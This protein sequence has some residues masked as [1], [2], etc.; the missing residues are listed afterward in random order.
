MRINTP[1]TIAIFGG[2]GDLT[3]KKLAPAL[4]DLFA[5]GHLP[6]VFEI[7]GFSRRELTTADYR[8][9]IREAIQEKG[10]PHDM[11][12]LERFLAHVRYVVGDFTDISDYEK[13]YTE[14]RSIDEEH[15]QCMSKL[16]YLAVPPQFYDEIFDKLAASKLTS[17]CSSDGSWTRVVVE[18]PFGSD[19]E[20]ARRLDAKLE[21]LFKEEQIY[22]IDHYL[23]KETIEN[24]LAFRFSNALFE[25]IWNKEHIERIHV[26]MHEEFGV[27]GRGAFY[28][29]VGAL[30]DVGQNHILQMLALTTME[31]PENMSASAI[32][33]SRA[34]LL[35]SLKLPNGETKMVRGQYH[36]YRTH[37]GVD[38]HS[39]TETYFCLT[40]HIDSSRWKGV[41]IV[42]EAGKKLSDTRTDIT[43]YFKHPDSCLCGGEHEQNIVTFRIQP[44]EGISVHFLAKKPGFDYTLQ[45]RTLS[46]DYGLGAHEL[47]DAY[48]RVLFD[49]IRG[50]Q[51]LFPSSKEI[52]A[53]WRY[54][55]PVLHQWSSLP[56]KEYEPG[57]EGFCGEMNGHV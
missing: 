3:R 41:P 17:V 38:L 31:R 29:G 42:L 50:D 28:D 12:M 45:D 6:E 2:T 32:R 30:R 51:T 25:P 11:V 54:I 7:V 8:T 15:G 46:F 4:L 24:L 26:S 48:E 57:S 52:L 9:F 22:R 18:K 23:A 43:V 55:T 14:V 44:N 56:L 19:L 36:G 37:E 21:S 20:T 47:P 39:E 10:H 1:T 40:A 13:L 5:G 34:M 49:A 27:G 35:D 16:I 33:S 53:Q